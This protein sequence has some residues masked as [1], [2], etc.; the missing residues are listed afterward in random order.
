MNATQVWRTIGSTLGWALAASALVSASAIA[1][2]GGVPQ[3]SINLQ[4]SSLTYCNKSDNTWTLTKTADMTDAVSGDTVTWTIT[5]TKNEGS[6]VAPPKVLCAE[7][8]VT[9]TN[10]GSGVANV[11][12]IVVNLQKNVLVSGKNRWV[13]AAADVA[14]SYS[15]DAA[16][17]A[18]IVAAASAENPTWNATAG[19]NNYTVSGAAGT[20]TEGSASGSLEFTD[21][22]NNTL[23]SLSPSFNLGAGASVTLKYKANFSNDVLNI[24]AGTAL[25]TEVIVTFGNAGGRGGSGASA[26]GID[27]NGDGNADGNVRSVPVRL[28]QTVPAFIDCN[29]E[30]SLEDAFGATGD[31]GWQVISN[32][33]PSSTSTGG[34]WTIETVVTGNGTV[35]N[36]VNL[37]GPDYSLEPCCESVDLT[38]S[39][40]VNVTEECTVN[41]NPPPCRP[42]SQFP[43]LCEPENGQFCTYTQGGW[44]ATPHGANPAALLAANFGTAFPS[45]LV[46]GSGYTMTFTAAS[47]VQAY[48]PAGG[49]AGVLTGSL[50]N[51]TSSSSGVFGGQTTALT[52]SVGMS[53]VGT[54]S[55]LGSV[56]VNTSQGQMSIATILGIMSTALG[57]GSTGGFTITELNDLGTN[58]NEAFDNC[59]VS[60]WAV[61]NTGA[62]ND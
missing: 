33:L 42:S 40:V 3:A 31:A 23:F 58:L 2:V 38:A 4:G 7:G 47:N 43:G 18:N 19:T 10:S 8:T 62:P 50:V 48:L 44:G 55:G 45:G 56:M 34:S 36:T 60:A 24:G 12:N 15:G 29:A 61:S 9:I 5:A 6:Q 49:T 57:G 27:I 26:T 46:V 37:F 30:V 11:G 39:A 41:C 32:N 16:T 28:T 22:S 25:R 13:S 35:G 21:A 54:P 20:F 52:I 17:T 53:G 1:D 59:V 51:T 14:T